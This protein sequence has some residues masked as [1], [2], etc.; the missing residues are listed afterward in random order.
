MSTC[1]RAC[2]FACACA[3]VSVNVRTWPAEVSPSRKY[4]CTIAW[5]DVS[6]HA[7]FSLMHTYSARHALSTPLTSPASPSIKGRR[8]SQNLAY[9]LGSSV[10]GVGFPLFKRA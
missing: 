9:T 3:T 1:V 6:W 2:V 4:E 10:R 5:S 8:G 7:S